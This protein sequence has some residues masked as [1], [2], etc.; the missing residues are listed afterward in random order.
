MLVLAAFFFGLVV[1]SAVWL[2]LLRRNIRSNANAI[3]SEFERDTAAMRRSLQREKMDAIGKLAGGAA[4]SFNNYLTSI[5][6]YSELILETAPSADPSRH[7]IESIKKAAERGS[8]FTRQLF[9]LN[10]RQALQLEVLS[11]N[12]VLSNMEPA[13][14]GQI[15]EAIDLR[16]TYDGKLGAVKTDRSQMEQVITNLVLQARD[17]L[18]NGGQ[19]AVSARNIDLAELFILDFCE[20]K[21]GPYVQ[22]EVRDSGGGMDEALRR[23]A[24]EPFAMPKQKSK[25]GGLALAIAYNIIQQNGGDISVTS[26]PGKG[27]TFT[28]YLPRL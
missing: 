19:I 20:L 14:R 5:L 24:F 12:T 3:R 23:H 26:E 17:N 1:A 28:V 18:P 16:I 22:L 2:L 10:R 25:G 8:E 11:L 21:P 15:G 13:L 9:I 7:G 4:H 27:T 6:G